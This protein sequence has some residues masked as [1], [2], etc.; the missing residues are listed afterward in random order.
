MQQ[1]FLFYNCGKS[2][3]VYLILCN[4]N[5]SNIIIDS[6]HHCYRMNFIRHVSVT[7]KL[8]CN[9]S[10]EARLY[11]RLSTAGRSLLPRDISPN[12]DILLLKWSQL[13]VLCFPRRMRHAL[14]LSLDDG[15]T[16]RETNNGKIN[17]QLNLTPQET[18]FEPKQLGTQ[19][20]RWLFILQGGIKRCGHLFN[21]TIVSATTRRVDKDACEAFNCRLMQLYHWGIYRKKVRCLHIYISP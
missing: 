13:E 8:K 10:D 20:T 9:T 14:C 11:G 7:E 4:K 12:V 5:G 18:G 3:S 19:R 2:L 6:P 16:E 15:K 17:R 1:P 21:F